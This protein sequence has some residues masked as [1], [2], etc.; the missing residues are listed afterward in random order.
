MANKALMAC[1]NFFLIKIVAG[2]YLWPRKYFLWKKEFIA[3]EQMF[4][5]SRRESIC[6]E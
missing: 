6:S 1:G 2:E 4:H 3:E 5:N